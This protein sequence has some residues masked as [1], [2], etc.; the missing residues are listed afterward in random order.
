MVKKGAVYKLDYQYRLEGDE[1]RLRYVTV[2]SVS[3]S[4]STNTGFTTRVKF[5]L[6]NPNPD[7]VDSEHV[8][9]ESIFEH[10]YT[11]VYDSVSD[12]IKENG[13]LT[14]QQ[15]TYTSIEEDKAVD[16]TYLRLKDILETLDDAKRIPKQERD[17]LLYNLCKKLIDEGRTELYVKA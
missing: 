14:S 10:Y 1:D 3:S 17:A 13:P 6:T 2:L 16:K 5:A 9:E 8:L 11:H 12:Y 15:D 7:E 4:G